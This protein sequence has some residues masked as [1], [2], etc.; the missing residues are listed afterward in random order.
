MAA[1]HEVSPRGLRVMGTLRWVLL[2]LMASLAAFSWW[3]IASAEPGAQSA[4]RYYCPMHPAVTSHDPGECPICH[5]T[6]EPIPEQ[7]KKSSA[8]KPSAAAPKASPSASAAP[9]G[10]SFSCP[11]HPEVKSDKPGS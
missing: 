2:A 9:Q 7:R 1:E 3:S 10:G 5:M 8:P 6:L 11:M 4:P